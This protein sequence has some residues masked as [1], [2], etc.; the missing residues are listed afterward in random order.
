M[1]RAI[2]YKGNGDLLTEISTDDYADALQ[3]K[4][5]IL[6]VDFMW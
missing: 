6:W 2:L 5:G 3:D 1:L 4:G